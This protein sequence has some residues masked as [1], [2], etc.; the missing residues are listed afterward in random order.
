MKEQIVQDILRY[1]DPHLDNGQLGQLQEVLN[2]CLRNVVMEESGA[3]AIV[4]EHMDNEGLLNA[5]LSA[6]RVE[7]CSEKTVRYYSNSIQRMFGEV[8]QLL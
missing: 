4:P 5:F 7:G 2:F 6:K 3:P 8:K 1:M